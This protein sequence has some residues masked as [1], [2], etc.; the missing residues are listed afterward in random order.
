MNSIKNWDEF[1]EDKLQIFNTYYTVFD[2][3]GI[4]D[5]HLCL[6]YGSDTEDIVFLTI[7]DGE[8]TYDVFAYGGEAETEAAAEN[9]GFLSKTED[10]QR[11]AI[12]E[13]LECKPENI[14][15]DDTG[16]FNDDEPIAIFRYVDDGGGEADILLLLFDDGTLYGFTPENEVVDAKEALFGK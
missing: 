4:E 1:K 10:E 8:V 7:E 9:G 15:F 3:L 13:Y 5:G 12:A 2:Q 16:T 14:I 11:E 6:Q